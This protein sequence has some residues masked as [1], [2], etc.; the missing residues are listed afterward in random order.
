MTDATTYF[1]LHVDDGGREV[2]HLSS[3][4]SILFDMAERYRAESPDLRRCV[5]AE[6]AS[7]DLAPLDCHAAALDEGM[8]G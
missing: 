1:I 3:D 2:A 6:Y 7:D 5:M 8:K 4:A